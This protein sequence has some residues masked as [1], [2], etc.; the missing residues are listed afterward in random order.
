MPKVIANLSEQ[1]LFEARELLL[2]GGWESLT[3]RSVAARCHVAVGT[4]YHYYPAKDALMAAVMLEDWQSTL[5]RMEEAS[6]AADSAA[7]G[8]RAVFAQLCAF[9]QQYQAIWQQYAL[10]NNPLPSRQMY[11]KQ[12][13]A[14]MA[15]VLRA[16]L[17]S[18]H[19][20]DDPVLPTFLAETL[21]H[22]AP[23][24]LD[25]YDRAAHLI[26]RLIAA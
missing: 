16:L 17:T 14:Q 23:Q 6:A 9:E 1:I 4:V 25:G 2:S 13:I 22:L 20:A 18:H 7:D 3:I 24:G 21:L 26:L 12:L 19:V 11:H 15:G 5:T 10:R 8:L